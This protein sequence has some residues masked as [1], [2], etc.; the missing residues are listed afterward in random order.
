M[1]LPRFIISS[2]PSWV[3]ID[4]TSALVAPS[5]AGK[6][7]PVMTVLSRC[8]SAVCVVTDAQPAIRT[9]AIVARSKSYRFILNALFFA[10]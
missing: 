1:M 2:I 6:R 10:D 7:L 4:L 3:L 8:G 5:R 9:A